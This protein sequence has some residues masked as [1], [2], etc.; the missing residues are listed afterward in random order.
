M[1]A[2]PVEVWRGIWSALNSGTEIAARDLRN[3][4]HLLDAEGV[5]QLPL[6]ERLAFR[7]AIVDA[8]IEGVG[9]EARDDVI[10]P[11]ARCREVDAPR[12][13]S[14]VLLKEALGA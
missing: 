4:P 9:R 12:E 10:E 7:A 3:R 2:G 11:L 13:L 1:N 8:L 6:L 14:G 5:A